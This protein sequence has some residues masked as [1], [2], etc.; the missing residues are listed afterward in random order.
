MNDD[1]RPSNRLPKAYPNGRPGKF[2]VVLVVSK[3]MRA[4]YP[5]SPLS[6]EEA[7]ERS[8]RDRLRDGERP[9]LPDLEAE[10]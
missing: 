9:A 3:E 6:L 1:R 8:R 5:D 4:R 7:L 10:P 2:V